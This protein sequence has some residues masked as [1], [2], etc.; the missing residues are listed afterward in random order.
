MKDKSE[1][2]QE[3]QSIDKIFIN[4]KEYGL[5]PTAGFGMGIDRF[6]MLLANASNINDVMLFPT[7]RPDLA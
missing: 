5:P 6:V 2:D 7:L 3:A 1:G 4:A